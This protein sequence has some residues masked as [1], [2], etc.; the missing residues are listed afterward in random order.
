MSL[1]LGH[2]V[3]DSADPIALAGFWSAAVGRPVDQ[4]A[5]PYF[6]SIDHQVDERL[7]W[8]FIKVPEAKTAKNRVHVDLTADDREAETRRLVE[9]GAARVGDHDEWGAVWTV[10]TDPEGNEFCVGQRR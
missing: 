9:L 4:D 5:S 1:E 10:L 3:F 6:A 8:F 2:L 7:S